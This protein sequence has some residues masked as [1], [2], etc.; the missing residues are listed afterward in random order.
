M[1]RCQA[2]EVTRQPDGLEF[3]SSSIDFIGSRLARRGGV[4]RISA[5]IYEEVR[6][7]I[8]DRLTKVLEQ[9]CM[10]TGK[11]LN[12]TRWTRVLTV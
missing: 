9:V 1:K 10:V 2:V 8:R 7:V 5:M 6:G 11:M 3:C 12:W 4:K